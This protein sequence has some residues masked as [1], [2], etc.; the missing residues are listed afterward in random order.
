M[1]RALRR[2]STQALTAALMIGA[3]SLA[4]AAHAQPTAAIAQTISGT[5]LDVS[6]TGEATRVPD[7]AIVNAGVVTRAATARAALEQ[8]AARMERVRNALRRAG[9]A[10][11]DIQTS[12]ISL[13]PEYRYVENRAPQLTGYTAS[14]QVSVRFRDIAKTGDILDAL[15]AEGANQINGP[16]LTI[17]EPE[18]ALNEARTKALA[19]GRARAELYARAL[20]MRVVRLLSVSEGVRDYPRPMEVMMSAADARGAAVGTKIDPGEQKLSV[21][22]GMVFELQ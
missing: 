13:N 3:A 4:S 15:V 7:I 8:N 6:A 16:S 9:I 5:R 17:D 22:L 14:N 12:N 19:A 2:R 11:R 1:R 21:M 10:D 18:E 20:N